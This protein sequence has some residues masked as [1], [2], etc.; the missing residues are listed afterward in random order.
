ME[1]PEG[2]KRKIKKY[3]TDRNGNPVPVFEGENETDV[4]ERIQNDAK[5]QK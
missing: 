4:A 2:E 1:N 3:L 5:E